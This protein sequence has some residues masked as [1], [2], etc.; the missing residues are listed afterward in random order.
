MDRTAEM[1]ERIIR[2]AP[3]GAHA[4]EC[5]FNIGRARENQRRNS[6]TRSMPTRRVLDSYPDELAWLRTLSTR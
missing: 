2:N 1:Y 4:A 3:Y 5:E 6:R